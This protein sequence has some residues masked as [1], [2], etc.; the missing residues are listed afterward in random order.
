MERVRGKIP[1]NVLLL[2][3][4][5]LL[6]DL[7]SEMVYPLVP[8]FLSVTLGAPASVVGIIEGFA[9]A[10]ASLFKFVSGALSDRWG[11]RKPF[12]LA[13]Y[14]LAALTKPL[15]ALA[16]GWPLVLMARVLD[17][18]GKGLRGSP[19]DALIADST[20]PELRGRAFGFHRSADSIGAVG[21]PL[22]ALLLLS[23]MPGD[24]RTA[25]L[26]AFIPGLLSTLLVLPVR[27]RSTPAPRRPILSLGVLKRS[28][29][30]LRRFL[31]ITLIF[32]LGN[33]SDMFL[34]LRA[35]QLGGSATTTVL[36]FGAFNLANVLCAYP[37]GI[38]SDR[39]G[40]K[41]LLALGFFLF[42]GIYV[43]V[44][45]AGSVTTL[46]LLFPLYGVY[47]ALTDGIGKAYIVDL[48]PAADRGAA[49]G[50]QAAMVGVATLPA[51]LV[52]GL[53]WDQIGAASAFLY[54]AATAFVAGLLMLSTRARAG[55]VLAAVLVC[56]AACRSAGPLPPLPEVSYRG[57]VLE[58]I[59]QPG[60]YAPEHAR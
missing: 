40:R 9:E 58:F 8:L 15:L 29:P 39:L 51:S 27:D 7:S 24:Y 42:A 60:R 32:A 36:L 23:W 53:L 48:A 13:G 34:I 6:T 43:G 28:D 12:C 52:A 49:L 3:G 2:S 38:V 35:Q 50:L 21:G 44:G 30:A 33:S 1:R 11:K 19:R 18:F 37:A 47:H 41:S 46:W 45:M 59:G 54:G 31:F 57:T 16:T 56:L 20:P 17:R 55:A 22:L 4:V 10:T 14:G 25:F 5:S 26:I